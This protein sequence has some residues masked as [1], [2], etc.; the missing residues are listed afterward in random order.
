LTEQASRYQGQLASYRSLLAVLD[1]ATAERCKTALYFTALD[2]LH[3]FTA[4]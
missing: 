2:Y 1:P 3:E 4:V